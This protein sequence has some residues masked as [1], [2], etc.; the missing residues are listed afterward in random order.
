MTIN[1][2][3][4]GDMVD[5]LEGAYEGFKETVKKYPFKRDLMTKEHWANAWLYV[6]GGYCLLEQSLKALVSFYDHQFDQSAMKKCSHSYS[7]P[8]NQERE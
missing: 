8:K 2:K 3:F 5:T 7:P 6:S 4:N 1:L